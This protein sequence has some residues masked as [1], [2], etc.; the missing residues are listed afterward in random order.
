M[1]NLTSENSKYCI[2]YCR[3]STA[4][5]ADGNSIDF[6]EQICRKKA[7]ME[8]LKVRQVYIDS[9]ISGRNKDRPEYKRM[10]TEMKEGDTIFIYSISRISRSM[11][12]FFE[13]LKEL[14]KKKVM[15]ISIKEKLDMSNAYG[16]FM[17]TI[18]SSLAELEA[19]LT[20]ERCRDRII[21]KKRKGETC[22]HDTFGYV[23]YKYHPNKPA[24]LIPV[25]KEQIA[26]NVMIKGRNENKSLR[27]II[28]M[29]K[30]GGYTTKKG[31]DFKPETIKNILLR[32]QEFRIKKHKT[33]ILDENL[34][35][36]Y[37]QTKMP[38]IVPAED[39]KAYIGIDGLYNGN[40]EDTNV[41]Y[42]N[43]NY[44]NYG[45]D[46]SVKKKSLKFYDDRKDVHELRKAN[47]MQQRIVFN[48]ESHE[49]NK[50]YHDYDHCL[51]LIDKDYKSVIFN[52]TNDEDVELIKLQIQL[53]MTEQANIHSEVGS[54]YNESR[55]TELLKLRIKLAEV[56][57]NMRYKK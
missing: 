25:Y 53:R 3:V 46:K 48:E 20:R 17:V 36:D 29:L 55:D 56:Q 10:R 51:D 43:L 40:Y 57:K 9:G 8:E 2:I 23:K 33:D 16:V 30:D 18:L 12:D 4:D 41:V 39:R 28:Q 32:E 49:R 7:E 52:E 35:M 44:L 15:L 19:N 31:G 37:I 47:D 21:Q 45:K 14:E 5:Q 38:L 34:I 6:Q 50:I 13:L 11:M 54:V 42:E 1:T 26:I 24:R 27:Q 22:S